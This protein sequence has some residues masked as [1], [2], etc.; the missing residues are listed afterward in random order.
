LVSEFQLLSCDT[1]KINGREQVYAYT[2]SFLHLLIEK[3]GSKL[4]N[5][6]RKKEGE[7]KNHGF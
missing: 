2:C 4:M 6:I 1:E 3:G 7:K 5:H